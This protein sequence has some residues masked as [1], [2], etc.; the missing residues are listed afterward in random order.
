MIILRHVSMS[1]YFFLFSSLSKWQEHQ[2]LHYMTV[3]ILRPLQQG[4]CRRL[5]HL[6]GPLLVS[7]PAWIQLPERL[8]ESL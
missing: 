8:G 1:L 3:K 6:C 7:V 4:L 5:L 2:Q